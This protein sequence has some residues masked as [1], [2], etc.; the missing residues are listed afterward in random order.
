MY[1]KYRR[2]LRKVRAGNL[3]VLLKS[4]GI[5]IPERK[6]IQVAK[7]VEAPKKVDSPK[8]AAA[9]PKKKE[10]EAA[11]EGEATPAI[12]KEEEVTTYE[13]YL[14]NRKAKAPVVEAPKPRTVTDSDFGG[15]VPLQR[16]ENGGTK[17]EKKSEKPVEKPAASAADKA[18]AKKE[19]DLA[20]KL[21][22]FASHQD[23]KRREW[24]EDN[25]R[26][27][28]ERRGGGSGGAPFAKGPRAPRNDH[29]NKGGN[30]AAQPP[31]QEKDFPALG[32]H[33]SESVKA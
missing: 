4:K 32:P 15:F 13:E 30:A 17:K 14:K 26:G 3:R 16:E 31:G 21:L 12:P 18:A 2:N 27:G 19:A 24:R 8:P 11:K 22:T 6:V 25:R 28:G 20:A 1:A 10:G 9:A 29:G 7:K 5:A 23:V 33:G